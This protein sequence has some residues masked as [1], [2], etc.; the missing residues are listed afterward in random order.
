[1]HQGSKAKLPQASSMSRLA[2]VQSMA[3][4]DPKLHQR[5]KPNL[6]N[7]TTK[8]CLAHVANI[9]KRYILR[10]KQGPPTS[11]K[12]TFPTWPKH[13]SPKLSSKLTKSINHDIRSR[14]VHVGNVAQ[15]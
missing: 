13:D 9:A 3:K 6:T 7:L 15:T 11:H 4:H 14:L 5:S 8:S 12:V 1:M 10:V 2:H